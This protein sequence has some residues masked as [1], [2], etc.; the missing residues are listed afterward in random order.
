LLFEAL[1]IE[2]KESSYEAVAGTGELSSTAAIAVAMIAG[3]FLFEHDARLTLLLSAGSVLA[4]GL[5]ILFV[6]ERKELFRSRWRRRGVALGSSVRQLARSVRETAA[7]P[8]LK[9]FLLLGIAFIAVYGTVEE[10]DTLYSLHIGV[11]ERFVGLWGSLRFAVVGAGAAFAS[12]L[13]RR[14]L[15]FRTGRL[16]AWMIGSGLA[17]LLGAL[18]ASAWGAPLYFAYYGMF[19]TAEVVYQG[20]LQR[21]IPSS[22]RATM[23]SLVSFL[24]TGASTGLGILLGLAADRWGLPALFWGGAFVSLAAAVAYAA[25]AGRF[26]LD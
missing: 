1:K 6:P 25:L 26:R 14:L 10:F 13:R 18:F 9:A 12:R 5:C 11:P 23:S 20:T 16:L 22:S 15:L 3:G 2:G 17:L 21:R 4:S 24:T 8:G 19:A 7:A